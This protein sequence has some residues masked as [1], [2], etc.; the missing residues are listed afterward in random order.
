MAAIYYFGKIIDCSKLLPKHTKLFRLLLLLFLLIFLACS[1]S[2]IWVHSNLLFVWLSFPETS[3]L[4]FKNLL[5]LLF[6]LLENKLCSLLFFLPIRVFILK[7]K[8]LLWIHF[9]PSLHSQNFRFK[10]QNKRKGWTTAATTN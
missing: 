1:W 8:F 10:L 9:K 2:V 7:C 5:R 6:L 3:T 4:S